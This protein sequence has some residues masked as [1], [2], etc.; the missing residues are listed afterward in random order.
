[1]RRTHFSHDISDH[2]ILSR[3]VRTERNKAMISI[4]TGF[5]FLEA[6]RR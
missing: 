5:L 2:G 4:E 3:M 1:M 6:L